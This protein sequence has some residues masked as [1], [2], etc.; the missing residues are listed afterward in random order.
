VVGGARKGKAIIVLNPAEPPLLMRDTV[1][2]LSESGDRGRIA[3]S[4][5]AMAAKVAAYVPGFRLKQAV[6]FEDIGA[7]RPVR[8]PGIGSVYGLKTSI[9]LEI[10][11]AAHY[12][13][14]FAGNLDIMTSAALATAQRLVEKR[15]A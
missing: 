14:A 3:A 2:C 7:N 12:L 15:A 6:Q 10:E 8:I 9:F 1:Y 4:V 5:E 13:P 11:G